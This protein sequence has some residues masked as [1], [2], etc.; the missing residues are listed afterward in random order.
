MGQ[1]QVLR[2]FDAP[3]RALWSI[4][5]WEGMA[6]LAGGGLFAAV[7]FDSP[8]AVIGS[9]KL[10][11]LHAGLPIRERLEWLDEAGLGYGYRLIDVGSLP[12]ADYEGSVRV[13]ACGPEAC[14]V[15]IRVRFVAVGM[16]DAAWADTWTS[17]ESGLLDSL[18][19]YL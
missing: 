15:L 7:E 13:S 19:A 2:R 3:A 10:V 6:R 9:T 8:R 1:A 18:D 4:V 12:I 5:S 16:D 14:I 11:R 17:M